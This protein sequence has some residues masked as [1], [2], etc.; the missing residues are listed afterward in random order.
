MDFHFCLD[1]HDRLA[2]CTAPMMIRGS[3]GSPPASSLLGLSLKSQ[4]LQVCT[5]A[6][7]QIFAL[8][9]LQGYL[10]TLLECERCIGCD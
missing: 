7:S 8:A 3:S 10:V 4:A 5:P 6:C 2:I 1:W 9:V